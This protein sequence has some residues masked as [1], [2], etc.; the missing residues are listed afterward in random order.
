M[1]EFIFDNALVWNATVSDIVVL[2]DDLDDETDHEF[3]K[4]YLVLLIN[5]YKERNACKKCRQRLDAYSM[6]SVK[7]LGL[8]Y[9]KR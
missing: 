6:A 5:R 4:D 1:R 2:S 7:M 9:A 3:G 8:V